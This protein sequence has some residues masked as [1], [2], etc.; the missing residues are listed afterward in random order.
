MPG[1][2]KF[3]ISRS[4]DERIKR[5]ING[6][7]EYN[8]SEF[9]SSVTSA[10]IL[11]FNYGNVTNC[12]G[13]T[14]N[15]QLHHAVF[16]VVGLVFFKSSPSDEDI[17]NRLKSIKEFSSS[18]NGLGSFKSDKN[19]HLFLIYS[20][21]ESKKQSGANSGAIKDV[22]KRIFNFTKG[23]FVRRRR[24]R[25]N[26]LNDPYCPRQVHKGPEEFFNLG[27]NDSLSSSGGNANNNAAGGNDDDHV[28]HLIFFI[29]GVGGVCDVRFRSCVEVVADFKKMANSLLTH[30]SNPSSGTSTP[31]S[32]SRPP[33]SL[34]KNKFFRR[35]RSSDSTN[36]TTSSTKGDSDSGS[37]INMDH[38]ENS[39]SSNSTNRTRRVECLPISWH[40]CTRR[41]IGMND[42]LS[43]IA[44]SSVPKLRHF[45]NK[46]VMDA[47]LYASGPVYTQTIINNVGDEINR[48][49][50]LFMEKHPN[51]NGSISLAGH[52]LGS[53]IVFDLL[54][55][56][57]PFQEKSTE[58]EQEFV[59]KE[60]T[61][62]SAEAGTT[63]S[64]QVS[65]SNN[66]EDNNDT[67]N[68][69]H[70]SNDEVGRLNCQN[71]SHRHYN[72]LT[73]IKNC[74]DY[75][76]IE[77]LLNDMNLT[78][79]QALFN[80]EHIDL[81][82]LLLLTD[83]DM[84]ELKLSLGARR[85]LG[86]YINYQ[87]VSLI[88]TTKNNQQNTQ[89]QSGNRGSNYRRN[90]FN[91]NLCDNANTG[92]FLIKYPQLKFKPKCFFSFGS[93]MP[94]FL[95]VRGI[96][97][98]SKDY[99]LPTCDRMFNIFHP[100]DPLAYR[101][102]PLIDPRFKDIEPVQ[103][104]HHRGGKRI[105]VQ[106]REGFARVGHDIKHRLL[107]SLRDT[108]TSFTRFSASTTQTGTAHNEPSPESNISS[109]SIESSSARR[110]RLTKS[111]SSS[112]DVEIESFENNKH[113]MN[114]LLPKNHHARQ[115]RS[116]LKRQENL[117][118]SQS[119]VT[120]ITSLDSILEG[121]LK[122]SMEVESD[123]NH[124]G[125]A[126]LMD[127]DYNIP[128]E[129]LDDEIM[130]EPS[131]TA[132][133]TTTTTTTKAKKAERAAKKAAKKRLSSSELFDPNKIGK[134]NLGRRLDYVLQEKPIELINEYIFA[135]TSHANYWQNEDSALIIL[136]EIYQE[137][138]IQLFEG[139]E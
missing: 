137:E 112:V 47:L 56:Q 60:A 36:T 96:Q 2:S 89:Q 128:T 129:D 4:L 50:T 62:S 82:T 58:P 87:K 108:W 94:M 78:K 81:T 9:N 110:G 32:S 23:T 75:N 1:K 111:A 19:E 122:Q 80:K 91:N 86:T 48:L 135:F 65:S 103:I 41:Q 40:S 74:S 109:A 34:K 67:N 136:N 12:V 134:L 95:N 5:I 90:D 83:L 69:N 15:Y 132:T 18:P 27:D 43:L 7:S 26:V 64:E 6:S 13:L 30:Q 124:K 46:V 70:N 105:H 72:E 84:K 28:D 77:E 98:I 119:D 93:P 25:L 44:L 115:K 54:A 53:V 42:Q 73:G 49:Y 33:S 114:H 107:G 131:S 121:S 14:T 55:N 45:L 20:V 100:Y 117:V 102:E 101:V 97:N 52:S 3:Q 76:N 79:Y 106:L 51:F 126:V 35:K 120:N 16:P 21:V 61:K 63:S 118:R 37:A 92:Q 127:D 57:K 68:N 24:L 130:L 22:D 8:D 104:P 31:S 99:K 66:H 133:T 139:C 125:A 123:I 39:S 113:F 88:S 10:Y 17:L 29:H 85:K 138:G 38:N 71:I 11:G 116:A 59:G